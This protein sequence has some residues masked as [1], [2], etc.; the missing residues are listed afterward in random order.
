MGAEEPSCESLGPHFLDGAF[1]D[2]GGRAVGDHNDFRIFY[3][4]GLPALF[5]VRVI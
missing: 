1:G 4:D 3:H 2:A 5:L